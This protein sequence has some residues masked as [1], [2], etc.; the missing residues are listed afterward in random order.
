M[1]KA[2][3]ELII[4][5]EDSIHAAVAISSALQEFNNES[6]EL[7]KGSILDMVKKE[8]P[9]AWKYTDEG[10]HGIGVPLLSDQYDLFIDY[11][12][13]TI[14]INRSDAANPVTEE[15]LVAKMSEIT[16]CDKEIWGDIVWATSKARYPGMENVD[17]AYYYYEL[18]RQYAKNP[19]GVAR[20]IVSI[21]QALE[22][23]NK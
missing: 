6:K 11:D 9:Q 14:N 18:Y 17:N 19:D 16:R 7:F 12:W 2:I 1:D 22:K 20:E 21:V 10:W 4:K 15:K 3:A 13:K 23:L 5:S 8:L